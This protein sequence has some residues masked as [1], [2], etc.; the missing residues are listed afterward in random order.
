MRPRF[1]L[2]YG[3]VI[4]REDDRNWVAKKTVTKAIRSGKDK[5]KL[6]EYEEVVG[7]CQNIPHAKMAILDALTLEEQ[8][9][10][11][12]FAKIDRIVEM[13]EE[14]KEEMNEWQNA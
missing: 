4:E 1:K 12:M 6:K 2:D 9:N 11:E 8:T 14:Y 10:T 5:G 3:Y 13:Y 7:Y